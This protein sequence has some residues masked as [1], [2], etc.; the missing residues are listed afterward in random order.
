MT[1]HTEII[2]TVPEKSRAARL[3]DS[4]HLACKIEGQ[5]YT[6]GIKDFIRKSAISC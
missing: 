6:S 5:R 4:T 3:N 2:W 1:Q